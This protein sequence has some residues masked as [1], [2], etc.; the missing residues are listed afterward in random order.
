MHLNIS[1]IV[2]RRNS[3][4]AVIETSTNKTKGYQFMLRLKEEAKNLLSKIIH[5]KR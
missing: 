2:Y 4:E 1:E 5:K 3:P